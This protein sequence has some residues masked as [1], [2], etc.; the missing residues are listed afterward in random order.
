MK[1][2]TDIETALVTYY[3]YAYSWLSYGT[4]LW[5]NGTDWDKV[6]I[7]QKRLV[8]IVA[9]IKQTESCKPYFKKYKILTLPCVYILETC[10][11]VR[12]Y[13]FFFKK[14]SDIVTKYA[15]RHQNR[16][17]L[18]NSRLQL[19]S[20]SPLVMS[21]KLY[22]K[23]PNF[24]KD[25]KNDRTFLRHIKELLTNKCYYSINEFLEDNFNRT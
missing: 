20:S 13:P 6:F 16:L 7:L 9:N 15:L 8:R 11:F 19:H 14:R 2:S 17:Q 23:L 3:A 21:I 1:K 5:G 25:I 10:K 12:K 18:P 24:I 4:I 22:N